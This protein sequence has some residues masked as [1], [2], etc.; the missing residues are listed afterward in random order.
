MILNV[1]TIFDTKALIFNTPFFAVADGVARRMC[2]DLAADIN[3]TVGRH[4]ADYVVYRLGTYDDNL[5]KFDLLE[6]RE[7]LVDIVALV[8]IAATGGP[9][10]LD[11]GDGLNGSTN[12]NAK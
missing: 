6:I 10:L 12:P 8:P 11:T 7:H 3:T 9:D 5:G 4:P 2:A 1:Y